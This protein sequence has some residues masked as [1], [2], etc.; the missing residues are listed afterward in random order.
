M[1]T[2]KQ[3][4]GPINYFMYPYA[5]VDGKPLEWLAAQKDL[6]YKVTFNKEAS[7]AAADS[8]V[9]VAGTSAKQ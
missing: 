5:E 3:A 8:P 6:K 9:Q 1:L 7:T 2:P 4:G